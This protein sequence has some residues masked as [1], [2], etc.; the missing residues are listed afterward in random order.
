MK[1]D[2]TNWLNALRGYA[3]KIRQWSYTC[4]YYE[5]RDLKNRMEDQVYQNGK[6]D[7]KRGYADSDYY[8]VAERYAKLLK[9]LRNGELIE[10]HVNWHPNSGMIR[11]LI[12]LLAGEGI[13]LDPNLIRG[14]E[15]EFQATDI[16][17]NQLRHR[18]FAKRIW[19]LY[20]KLEQQQT[21]EVATSGI[22]PLDALQVL[23]DWVKSLG[24]DEQRK[25]GA[26]NRHALKATDEFIKAYRATHVA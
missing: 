3:S 11:F 4:E 9:W 8:P 16:D 25:F 17:G 7:L 20:Q 19:Y 26:F 15:F 6:V 12:K 22:T 2:D 18:A 5:T 24:E 1:D 21:Q 13:V 10:T 23:I 14:D